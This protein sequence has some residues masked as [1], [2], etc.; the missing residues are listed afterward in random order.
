MVS[1]GVGLLLAGVMVLLAI[2]DYRS[3][4]DENRIHEDYKS[5]IINLG[6][7]GT[8][9]GIIAGLWYFD[10]SDI[11]GSVPPLLDGLKTAFLTSFFGMGTTTVLG[12]LQKKAE[13]ENEQSETQQVLNSLIQINENM[14]SGQKSVAESLESIEKTF[15]KNSKNLEELLET[16]SRNMLGSSRNLQNS[17]SESNKALQMEISEKLNIL[18]NIYH[19]QEDIFKKLFSINGYSSN[20]E[21]IDENVSKLLEMTLKEAL[22]HRVDRDSDY[23]KQ[24]LEEIKSQ[25]TELKESRD[26]VERLK[27]LS[28]GDS[29]K[30][31][32]KIITLQGQLKDM[33]RDRERA[34]AEKEKR[35]DILEAKI[36]LFT[37]SDNSSV[38]H[39]ETPM[40]E[41]KR[42]KIF[43]KT[44]LDKTTN[45]MWEKKSS[46]TVREKLK[47]ED[48]IEYSKKLNL[49]KFGKF[50][51]WR[52]A[53]RDELRTLLIKQEN[54]GLYV[55]SEISESVPKSSWSLDA[56]DQTSPSWI[57]NFH[58]RLEL[59]PH[60]EDSNY[61]ICVRG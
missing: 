29:S 49:E 26:E 32:E 4:K 57:V 12:V 54:N 33:D 55:S 10:S 3:F 22:K 45:L 7:L 31:K 6:I 34:L 28:I 61:T 58:D 18:G 16:L 1:M 40:E 39:L 48:A 13:S 8:F 51:D 36:E 9:F 5:S 17:F 56:K 60:R 30:F 43:S 50:S 53:T 2:K 46:T 52:V 37:V 14:R 21:S 15:S 44:F 35:I 41:T 59:W 20:L 23:W 47:W 38:V 11:E 24:F 19:I 27:E 25:R 42:F